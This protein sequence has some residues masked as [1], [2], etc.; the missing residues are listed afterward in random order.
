MSEYQSIYTHLI[1]CR[2]LSKVLIIFSI[3]KAAL[4]HPHSLPV[5]QTFR[6]MNNVKVKNCILEG[7][8]LVFDEDEGKIEQFGGIRDFWLH[9]VSPDGSVKPRPKLE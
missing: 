5:D 4:G 3:I 7:E 8:L 9:E 2:Y 6:S 1:Y